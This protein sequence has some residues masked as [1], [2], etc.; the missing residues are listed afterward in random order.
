MGEM[1]SAFERAMEKVEKMGK[2]TDEELK[3]LEYVP[4]GSALA[5]RYLRE[6]KFDLAGELNKYTD[7]NVRKHVVNGMQ[8]ALLH[9]ITL[10]KDDMSKKTTNK[11]ISG[12]KLTK[13]SKNQL[14]AL[15]DRISSLITYY[16]QARQ[17][18]FNQ[19]KSAFESK[20]PELT[21]AMQQ[22]AQKSGIPIETQVQL[23]FQEQWR[24]ASSEL[25]GQYEKVLEEH[26]QQIAALM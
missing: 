3:R 2:A 23:Q 25:D 6:E 22:Q 7:E 9:N 10:P 19:F 26:K 20:L 4:I 13:K 14:D 11:A 12:L 1:K 8:E 15:L 5:A 21:R 24:R 17:Q 16:E 18:A